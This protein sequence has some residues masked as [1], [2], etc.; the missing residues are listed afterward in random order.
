METGSN[1]Q[2]PHALNTGSGLVYLTYA[3]TILKSA[4]ECEPPISLIATPRLGPADLASTGEESLT[5]SIL[6]Q[7][8]IELLST[9]DSARAV[10]LAW[11]ETLAGRNVL[12]SVPNN[13]LAKVWDELE[14]M[15][16]ATRS[17]KGVL[18]LLLEDDHDNEPRLCPR[19]TAAK[20]GIPCLE[21]ASLSQLRDS[22]EFALRLGRAG[23]QVV[24]IICHSSLVHSGGSIEGRPNRGDE[25]EVLRQHERRRRWRGQEGGGLMRVARR[26]ELNSA[27]ALPSPGER[28]NFGF[29]TVGVADPSLDYL[30]ELF[31]LTGRVP[32]LQLGLIDPVDLPAI[33]RILT[34]CH[35]VIVLETR[36]GCV[37]DKIIDAAETLRAQGQKPGLIWGRTLPQDRDG[38]VRTIAPGDVAHPSLLA[39]SID[40]LL[41]EIG[42]SR[43][44]QH[45]L[46][47]AI[48]SPEVMLPPRGEIV[49]PAAAWAALQALVVSAFQS[50]VENPGEIEPAALPTGL[51]IDGD[52]ELGTRQQPTFIEKW[53][54]DAFV[55]HG[56]GAIP[57]AALAKKNCVMLIL[58]SS[59]QLDL[60][61]FATALVPAKVTEG[62]KILVGN[63]DD[64]T[65]LTE[66]IAEGLLGAK[67]TVLIVRDG[68]PPRFDVRRIEQ[69][70]VEIDER[71]FQPLQRLRQ[72]AEE[73]CRIRA[74]RATVTS[75]REHPDT[76]EPLASV[77]SAQAVP[78][79]HRATF[80]SRIR[81]LLEQVEVI[82]TRPPVHRLRELGSEVLPTPTPIHGKSAHWR[83]HLAGYRGDPPGLIAQILCQAAHEMGYAV[84]VR[85]QPSPIGAGRRA[86]SQLLFSQPRSDGLTDPPTIPF[87]DADLLLGLD[88]IETA[89]A[90]APDRSLRVANAEQT[91]VVANTG[92]FDADHRSPDMGILDQWLRE[93]ARTDIRLLEDVASLGRSWFL[94][95]RLTDLVLLGSAFQLGLIP[96]TADAMES[97]VRATESPQFGRLMEAFI[98]GRRLVVHRD[99]IVRPRVR[100]EGSVSRLVRRLELLVPPRRWWQWRPGRFAKKHDPKR[101]CQ[102]LTHSISLMPGML[103]TAPGRESAS[104][105]VHSLYRC[106][107]WGGYE[108]AKR[109]ADLITGLYSVDRADHGR[110]L[111]RS[112]VLP[113]ADCMLIRDPIYIAAMIVSRAHRMRTRQR[114]DVK[115]ARGDE[116]ERRFLVRFELTV[117]KWRLRA[118]VRTSDWMACL[119]SELR[120]TVPFRWRGTRRQREL[121][122]LLVSMAEDVANASSTDHKRMLLMFQTLNTMVE[123]GEFR[124]AT[125]DDITRI[126][127]GFT[128]SDGQIPSDD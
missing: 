61:R 101:F 15:T 90:I 106:M 64:V 124:S 16:E 91:Y 87:G 28:A 62:T 22:I 12:S 19:Q 115:H 59:G 96:L 26:M 123:S 13:Q 117:L 32:I 95:D 11:N 68:P 85:Y 108:Y 102:L 53:S 74:R 73:A 52:L 126:I 25:P 9:L 33:S 71:G 51:V 121:R 17:T 56:A 78:A 111:T 92:E 37:M 69:M 70:L 31:N 114:L 50:L 40:H 44:V 72:A 128:E 120:H 113:L 34:R 125:S 54:H 84:A 4:L 20:F 86:W 47:P 38:V 10:H 27:S 1:R 42:P 79:G 43:Q 75:E 107:Q 103:E 82:R 3:Q 80:R 67:L 46:T 88:P 118:D 60:E 116:I 63:L 8:D 104:D 65:A 18:V 112:A 97:A 6:Q 66:A 29:I 7:H 57:Q 110:Q 105:F 89:R 30:V 14:R 45:H 24:A 39:R 5:K 48:L 55:Q 100:T 99:R 93:T 81:P 21:P 58:E 127:A 49:G 36:P 98:F 119:A 76:V 77:F 83:V 35:Q 94:T 109:Y 2:A 23:K 41:H 122:R